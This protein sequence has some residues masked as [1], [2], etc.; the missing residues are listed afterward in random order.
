MFHGVVQ[1]QAVVSSRL[2]A[3][4]SLTGISTLLDDVQRTRLVAFL[5][6]TFVASGGETCV[7]GPADC[8]L[9]VTLL[10][11]SNLI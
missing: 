11:N 6:P 7:I 3:Q 2:E 10:H 4:A 8:R 9:L 5:R 1:L